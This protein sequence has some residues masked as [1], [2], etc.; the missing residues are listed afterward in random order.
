M[1][2][3][4]PAEVLEKK[5]NG[6]ALVEIGGVRKDISLMLTEGVEVGDYVLVHA[7]FAIETIDK[8]EAQKTLELLEEYA[9]LDET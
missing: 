3:A 1:C 7:G 2:L 5:E 4:I 9:R 8:Y 6:I